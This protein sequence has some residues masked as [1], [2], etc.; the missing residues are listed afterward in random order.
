MKKR[1]KPAIP[2]NQSPKKQEE[3]VQ[4]PVSKVTET[5][6]KEST[7]INTA[8][9]ISLSSR[10]ALGLLV[11]ILVLTGFWIFKDFVLAKKTILYLD[12]GSDMGNAFFPFN[13]L[14]TDYFQEYGLL[15]WSF[16]QGMGQDI[17]P[18]MNSPLY[19][20]FF[21]GNAENIPTT[22]VY[23]EFLRLLLN[24]LTFFWYLRLIKYNTYTS[25]LG[26]VCFAL[27]GF[28]AL[29]FGW[30][31]ILSD[32]LLF[33]VLMLISL[34]YLIQYNKWYLLPVSVML[35]TINQPFNLVLIAE[36]SIIYLIVKLYV[37][38]K[39]GDWLDNGKLIFKIVVLGALGIGMGFFMAYTHILTMLNSPRGSGDVAYTN[40]LSS[41]PILQMADGNELF[42]SFLRWF[43]NDILGYAATY[44][45]WQ[46]YM[47]A[48]AFYVGLG[49]LL[50]LPQLFVLSNTRQRKAYGV[51]AGLVLL[52]MIFPY[53]RY[54]FWLF[55]G[56]YYRIMAAF[57]AIALLLGSLKVIE[58]ILKGFKINLIALGITFAFLL[59]LLFYS[60]ST[61]L[62]ALINKPVR[63][64]VV[65]FL[66]FHTLILAATRVSNLRNAMLWVFLGLTAVELVYF[67]SLTINKR[68][69]QTV[70]EFKSRTGFNDYTREALDYI[71]KQDKSFF[72]VEK[73][74]TSG[75]A[76]HASLNDAMIQG[77]Q[78]TSNYYSFNHKSYVSFM[79][80]LNIIA[81]N[82][83]TATRW[84]S[85]VRGR[86][87][88]MPLT[89]LKYYLVKEQFPFQ[90]FGF[91]SLT[92]VQDVQIFKNTFALPMGFTLDKYIT[93]ENFNK[94]SMVEKDASV[95]R[96]FIIKNAEKATYSAF[97]EIKDSLQ[98]VTL[99][100]Y[101]Q[102]INDCKKDTLQM[103]SHND[104]HFEGNIDLDHTKLLF[105]S[106]PYDKGWKVQVDGKPTDTQLVTFGMTGVILDKGKHQLK[107]YYDAPYFKTGSMVSGISIL[108]FGLL[109]GI[110][111]WQK[112]RKT[113][114]DTEI[115]A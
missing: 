73:G 66:L 78:S 16:K 87:L 105:L 37:G 33:L 5:P 61:D 19:Y 18:L 74:Y 84:I 43:S 31:P 32:W 9:D 109:L 93:E 107:I 2:Q 77:Y 12:I 24:G 97:T 54:T 95:Y 29:A 94:L 70:N 50:L 28:F 30:T 45:S 7:I 67:D 15:S 17:S 41:Q 8:S 23:I 57:M 111:F 26:S 36:F 63:T 1:N 10:L 25:I 92:T 21:L 40:V 11:G 34:E 81:P 75:S 44:K 3:V 6:K 76:I 48:P 39:L 62:A 51:V 58:A 104:Q 113:N 98:T 14:A 115:D 114:I 35:M 38:N 91:D 108:I 27:I 42:T 56:N 96:G 106:I 65:I 85:G 68:E 103:V 90:R 71:N 59:F 4:T 20:F 88:L 100:A 101:Q 22:A 102:L 64:S 83:E 60:F 79:K 52:T 13:K 99:E 69:I 53:F 89:S 47:E 72:R 82:E 86:P 80:G 110:S 55:T 46:N 49:M 112:K